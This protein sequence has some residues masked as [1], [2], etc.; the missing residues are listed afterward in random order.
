MV[1]LVGYSASSNLVAPTLPA[2]FSSLLPRQVAQGSAQAPP[3][4][5][6]SKTSAGTSA[7]NIYSPN[8]ARV[9]THDDGATPK[10]ASRNIVPAGGGASMWCDPPLGGDLTLRGGGG[11]SLLTPHVA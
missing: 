2:I 11:G 10:R 1:C 9:L 7:D 3:P 5:P 8:G 4:P 6:T